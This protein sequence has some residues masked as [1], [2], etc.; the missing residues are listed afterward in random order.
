MSP[1]LIRTRGRSIKLGGATRR[2]A[3]QMKRS[4]SARSNQPSVS[5]QWRYAK[6]EKE[7]EGRIRSK[8]EPISRV[9]RLVDR[10]GDEQKLVNQKRVRPSSKRRIAD[11]FES[12]FDAGGF[13]DIDISGE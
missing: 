9:E 5:T 11:H 13:V 7:G 2:N 1:R 4:R 10:V 8:A 12:V 3:I 6:R